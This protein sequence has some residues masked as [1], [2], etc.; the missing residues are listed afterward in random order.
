MNTH[1]E[2]LINNGSATSAATQWPGGRGVVMMG[3]NWSGGGTIA[4]QALLPN[5][6]YADVSTETT[7]TANGLGGFDLPPCT[8]K[9]TVTG[10]VAAAYVSVS[11]VPS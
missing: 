7:K 4:L 8:I 11:R 6:S 2:L 9:A 3:A 10:T 5:G 1:G